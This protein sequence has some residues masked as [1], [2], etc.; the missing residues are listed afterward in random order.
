[1][2][3]SAHEVETRE[4]DEVVVVAAQ[5]KKEVCLISCHK[6]LRPVCG[7]KCLCIAKY[8]YRV[9]HKKKAAMNT[10]GHRGRNFSAA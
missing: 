1:M 3:A 6:C 4:L 9:I 2:H 7:F 10:M 5:S 8:L